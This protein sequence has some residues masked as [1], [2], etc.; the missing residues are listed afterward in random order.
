MNIKQRNIIS[1]IPILVIFFSFME[2]TC[3]SAP[4]NER[5]LSKKIA[6]YNVE[7]VS[8][9]R[10]I[11]ILAEEN[12]IPIG[13]ITINQSK[14]PNIYVNTDPKILDPISI[15]RTNIHLVSVLNELIR[16]SKNYEWV[17]ID[18]VINIYPK[19]FRRQTFSKL[20]E[21]MILPSTLEVGLS[22]IQITEELLNSTKKARERYNYRAFILEPL[23]SE[24]LK[25]GYLRQSIQLD[26]ISIKQAINKIISESQFKFWHILTSDSSFTLDL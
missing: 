1:T 2:L 18:N 26:K 7:K 12:N 15:H 25:E 16:Q 21:E 3:F 9:I 20:I 4:V 6:S 14:N 23:R 13:V 8:F 17:N 22:K 11:K 24:T 5:L 19:L 10:A